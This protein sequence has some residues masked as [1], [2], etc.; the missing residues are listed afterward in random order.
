M[1]RLRSSGIP[2]CWCW[3][4]VAMP[5]AVRIVV[6]TV[7][8]ADLTARKHCTKIHTPQEIL[9]DAHMKAVTSILHNVHRTL[10][11]SLLGPGR[12]TRLACRFASREV[13]R[14]V[15]PMACSETGEQSREHHSRTRRILGK[16]SYSRQRPEGSKT[17][18]IHSGCG[19]WA[20]DRRYASDT[21]AKSRSLQTGSVLP[22][23]CNRR[24]LGLRRERSHPRRECTRQGRTA[25][26][27]LEMLLL[28][29]SARRISKARAQD[30]AKK[31]T[32]TI[33]RSTTQSL[34]ISSKNSTI[35][36]LPNYWVTK[37]D[38]S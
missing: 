33:P 26:W 34:M 25:F 28:L 6:Q 8:D 30:I 1:P 32:P 16:S 11:I 22:P 21:K 37:A 18:D 2:P 31:K 17:T 38:F 3:R 9:F 15:R 4:G 5:D 7:E 14:N 35:S 24:R 19:T 20:H 23:V 36:V 27:G 10:P 12:S 13:L 29:V